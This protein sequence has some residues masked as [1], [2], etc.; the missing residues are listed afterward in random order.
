MK[1]H[2]RKDILSSSWVIVSDDRE[3]RP[4]EYRS[5]IKCPFCPG[6]EKETPPE[7]Y[8]LRDLKGWYLRV[9]PNKYP[10]L[11][12][13]TNVFRETEGI[14]IKDYVNGIHEVIIE[15][16]NHNI[17]IN[18]IKHLDEVLKTYSLRMKDLYSKKGIR[19][20][21]LFRNYGE[22]AGA[23]LIHPHSQLI[24]IPL[25]P[26]RVSDE[27]NHFKGY[28]S[29]NKRCVMCDI[30]K[31]EIRI[32]KRIIFKNSDFIAF[33]PFASRFNFEIWISPVNHNPH[34]Y[35][36]KDFKK[37]SDA[38]KDVFS[39]LHY[40]IGR[41][42][43]NMIIHTAPSMENKFHWHIEILPKIAMPA[44]FEWGSGF[45]INS[46]SPERVYDILNRKK[47]FKY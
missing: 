41:L 1:P 25:L 42:S 21:M 40:S 10:A 31:N 24:A 22:N 43:Y 7:I 11:E 30:I 19:Y 8:S 37:L 35:C 2:L 33:A 46:I 18:E 39:K 6:N 36:E 20:V 13:S 16:R 14:N 23:S 38:L 12:Y 29:K 26:L 44:G 3:L 27:L 9:V 32:K 28:Y 4:N 17:K 45:Y 5:K 34:F 15:D 47:K